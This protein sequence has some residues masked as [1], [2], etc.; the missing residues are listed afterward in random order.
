V[1]KDI[2]FPK[3][4]LANF[5]LVGDNQADK[6]VKALF[7]LGYN[8]L[9]NEDYRK[10]RLNGQA[11]PESFPEVLSDYFEQIKRTPL[12]KEQLK[13][14]A[15][16]F[17]Q[18]AQPIILCLGLYSL[19]YCYAAAK[20]AKVLV[21]SKRILDN[22]G[23]RLQETGDFVLDV[24]APDAFEDPGKAFISIAKV[25]L[26][27]AAIRYHL[28][29]SKKW[30]MEDGLPINQMDMAGTNYSF[31]LIV[32]RGLRKLGFEISQSQATIYIQFWNQI[33]NILGLSQ[34][35]MPDSTKD[36]FV[37]EQKIRASEFEYSEEGVA[38]TKALLNYVDAQETPFP[39]KGSVI[40]SYLLGEELTK[41]LGIKAS[42]QAK[43]LALPL[44][45]LNKV[46]ST[47]QPSTNSYNA[48]LAEF[49]KQK[50]TTGGGDNF[51]FLMA[52]SD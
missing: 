15:E 22:P 47:L 46:Q 27:H 20:G 41:M 1:I 51:Q 14:G 52:L 9:S 16:F 35:L 40:S 49:K 2:L 26:M 30:D 13:K 25:R 10:Y 29:Q 28:L 5:R 12:D 4:M 39:L 31:S 38:L 32:I 6:V 33:G 37:L 19:P 18:F 48:L 45:L 34:E 44:K 36:A 7:D 17:L 43:N 50:F 21:S 42:S 3:E 8:P 23:K 24:H 11:M